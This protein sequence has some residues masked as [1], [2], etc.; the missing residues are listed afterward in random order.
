MTSFTFART[1]TLYLG[2]GRLASLPAFLAAHRATS[3]VLVTG[4][5]SFRASDR[6]KRLDHDLRHGGIAVR[7]FAVAGEPDPAFVDDSVRN[8]RGHLPDAVVA[9]GGGSVIDAG[10]AIAAMVM[11]EG[12]VVDFLEDVGSRTPS[13][14]KVPFVALP[15]TAGTGSEATKNAVLSRSGPGGFKKS[16]RHDNYVPDVA[17]IDPEL[18]V[19]CPPEVTAASGLDAITQLLE[20]FVSTSAS[21]LSD[22][23]AR[24]GLRSAGGSFERVT[25]DGDVASRAQM[26]YA[27]YLSGV[28]L[29]NAG[30]GVVHGIASPLGGL[31]PIPHGVVCGTLV[32]EAT[33]VNIDR[34][35]AASPEEA[36]VG[37]EESASARAKYAEA[38]VLLSGHDAGSAAANCDQLV[39]L[40]ARWVEELRIPRLGSFGVSPQS[41]RELAAQ[42]GVKNGPVKL[43]P[44]EI[45]AIMAA[46]L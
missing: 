22:A 27:A 30:L 17:I 3:I 1:P 7:S 8:L 26:G 12:S 24:S 18:A 5:H 43:T 40:L 35:A 36:A 2:A 33:R 41:L 4:A 20:G 34:L 9:I 23:L 6:L 14:K 45:Y 10:K 25:R 21:P 37:T 15:T 46:R 39:A 19:S 44:D 11:E 29:A 16:L 31:F 28:V 32:A 38:G 42:S 13:G